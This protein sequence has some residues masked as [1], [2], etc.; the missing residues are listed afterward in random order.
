[1]KIGIV[2]A[3][4]M[5]SVYGALLAAAGNEL[6]LFDS[7]REHIDAILGP[8]RNPRQGV[9]A[10]DILRWQKRWRER[11]SKSRVGK[12]SGASAPDM[13]ARSGMDEFFAQVRDA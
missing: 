9:G 8:E 5:G 6:W 1:M 4:A 2:G 3:G 12:D 10:A 7:W 13:S 11:R